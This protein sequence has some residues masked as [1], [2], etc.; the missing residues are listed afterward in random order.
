MPAVLSVSQ[1]WQLL[2][3]AQE[4]QAQVRR[5]VVSNPAQVALLRLVVHLQPVQYFP[6]PAA[7]LSTNGSLCDCGW[8]SALA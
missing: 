2:D 1:W 3:A 4:L 6:R 8:H 5:Q 7:A